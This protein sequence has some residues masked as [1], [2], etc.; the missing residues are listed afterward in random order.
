MLAAGALS[1][2]LDCSTSIRRLCPKAPLAA[3]ACAALVGLGGCGSDTADDAASPL[4]NALGYLPKDAPLVAS[5]D[6]DL[7]GDQLSAVG[8]ILDRFA[9]GDSVKKSVK[10]LVEQEGG[11]LNDIKPVLGNEFVVG[12][13]NAR[14]LT[15]GSGD[16]DFIGAIQAKSKDE[17]AKAIRAGK[18]KREGKRNGAILYKDDD[19]SLFA[20]KGDVLVVAGSRNLLKSAVDQRVADGRLTEDT[21][22]KA[23]AVL[24]KDALL[25]VG[26]D[27]QTLLASDPSTRAARRIKWVNALRTFGVTASFTDGE[28]DVGFRLNTDSGDLTDEDLPIASGT[29]SPAVVDRATDIVTGIKD[30][31]QI[32]DFAESA[33]QA[34]D[35]S[36]FGD[37]AQAKRTIEKQLG[38]SIQND[39]L[40]QLKGGVSITLGARGKFGARA[41]V[42]NP[43]AFDRTLAKLGKVLPAVARS[44]VG[45]PVGYAKPKQ[46]G[47]YYALTTAKKEGVVYGVIHGVFVLAND[48]SLASQLSSEDTKAVS[49]AAG[50]VVLKADAGQLVQQLLGLGQLGGALVAGPFGDLTGSMSADTSG[51]T[52]NFKLRFDG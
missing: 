1:A 23:T 47:D 7:S 18:S 32:V 50:S 11:A 12:A 8:K 42:K 6:T 51:I 37:Y 43:A 35:P 26:G 28:A 52:G 17:L 44:V 24:P 31:T 22:D 9:F 46:G 40:D 45:E 30:P 38:V 39:L 4:D 19:G 21:F 14:S 48:P 3:V 27:L 29:S 20:I 33:A 36:G 49:G 15:D 16:Q 5:I 25:R 34:I 2:P 41:R 10:D 13:T